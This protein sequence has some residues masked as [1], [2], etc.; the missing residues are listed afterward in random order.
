MRTLYS[1]RLF[2]A[3]PIIALLVTITACQNPPPPA[4]RPISVN[5]LLLGEGD[6][7]DVTLNGTPDE[8]LP[9]K[10]ELSGTGGINLPSLPDPVMAIGKTPHELENIIHDRYID[11]R[12]YTAISV[13]VT[14]GPRYFYVTGAVNP[15]GPGKQLYTG[16][17]TVLGAVSAAGGFNEFAAK[18]RVQ[19][20]RQDGKIYIEDCNKALKDPALDLEVLPNDKIFVD[21]LKLI[22]ITLGKS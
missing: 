13:T 9:L 10:F 4:V 5:L 3:V 12:I 17:V 18:F 16:K 6:S 14:P 21:K 7:I 20:T 2:R 19:L 11:G 15:N 1:K 22:E 8:H